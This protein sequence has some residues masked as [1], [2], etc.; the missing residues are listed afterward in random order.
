MAQTWRHLLF[1]HWPV[2]R[3]ALQLFIPPGLEL[4]ERDGTAWLGIVPFTMTGVRPRLVPPIPGLSSTHELNVRTYVTAGGKP[5]VWF[6]SLDASSRSTVWGARTFFHLPYFHARMGLQ[7]DG[8]AVT[9]SSRRIEPR[10]NPAELQ[11]SYAPTGAVH[12]APRGSLDE[13]LTERYCL[14]TTDR[15]GRLRRSKIHHP[16][17]L[18]QAASAEIEANTMT[19][20]LGVHLPETPPLLHFS[21]RQDVRVW[22]LS[23]VE[24]E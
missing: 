12:L 11:V 9:L 3:E 19:S 13:W 1:M 17:W 20:R 10:T 21:R 7:T 24:K 18:L 14:Y 23:R 4:E 16:P 2:P 8:E 15:R 5:G 6:F 22:W